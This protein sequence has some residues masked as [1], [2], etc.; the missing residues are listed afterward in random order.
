MT[1][2]LTPSLLLDPAVTHL[3]IA[4]VDGKWLAEVH[5]DGLTAKKDGFATCAEAYHWLFGEVYATV[6]A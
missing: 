4:L 6:I 5:A 3:R 1:K 2:L